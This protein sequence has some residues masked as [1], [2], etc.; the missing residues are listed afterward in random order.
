MGQIIVI[1]TIQNKV[2]KHVSGVSANAILT[3]G[4]ANLRNLTNS[5]EALRCL[6]LLWSK[7]TDRTML[8]SVSLV[9]ASVPFT[10]AMEVDQCKDSSTFAKGDQRSRSLRRRRPKRQR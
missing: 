10:L 5:P 3:A 8:L 2:P 9:A 6:R 7:A 4:V 1:N